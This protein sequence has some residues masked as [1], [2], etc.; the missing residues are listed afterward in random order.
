MSAP[1]LKKVNI[2]KD[3]VISYREAGKG[4]PVVILHGLGGRSESWVPQYEGL[5]NSNLVIGWDAPGY[6]LSSEMQENEPEIADYM[7]VLKRFTDALGLKS[8]HLVGHSVGTCIAAAF[9]QSYPE[10]LLSLTLAEAVIGSGRDP[11]EKQELLIAARFNE[12]KKMSPR[13]V[14][15]KKTP[16]SLSPNAS[17]EIIQAATDFASNVKVKG[18]LRLFVSLVRVNIFD[19]VTSLACS[20]M[21]IAGSEDKS[22]PAEFVKQI[23]NAYPGINYHLIEGIGHQIAFEKPE[24]F[25]ELLREH[26][27]NG[28]S[29]M[30]AAE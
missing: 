18:Y 17:S 30:Q 22:A 3:R 12:F 29:Q 7:E 13:E 24:V 20:A 28:E 2:G 8:F 9:H 21:I 6:N 11:K 19:F 15:Q 14:A 1:E 27:K 25:V 10:Q 4:P 16:N 23:A 26:F 5:S